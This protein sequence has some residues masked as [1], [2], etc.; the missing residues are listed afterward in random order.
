LKQQELG[1]IRQSTCVLHPQS[2]ST[3]KLGQRLL[4]EVI[5]FVAGGDAQAVKVLHY[6]AN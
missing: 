4:I 6:K 2:I 5:F 1:T 3:L